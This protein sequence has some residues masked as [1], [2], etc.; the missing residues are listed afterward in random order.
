MLLIAK[1]IFRS[2]QRPFFVS[3]FVRINNSRLKIRSS[4]CFS[5]KKYHWTTKSVPEHSRPKKTRKK[6]P[7][8]VDKEEKRYIYIYTV[9]IVYLII[10]N[11]F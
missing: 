3:S 5:Y 6:A 11:N 1:E 8:K 10:L 9:S 7:L 4:L 2:T